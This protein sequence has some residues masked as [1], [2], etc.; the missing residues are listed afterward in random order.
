MEHSG[1]DFICPTCSTNES[2]G[3]AHGADCNAP[4]SIVLPPYATL[5]A[6]TVFCHKVFTACDEAVYYQGN[7]FLV[8]Y[9]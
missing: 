3:N 9:G 1:E 6:G 7:L 2:N 5:P 4:S 8:P